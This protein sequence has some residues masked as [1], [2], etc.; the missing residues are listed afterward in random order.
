[1]TPTLHLC[2]TYKNGGRNDRKSEVWNA[3][4]ITFDIETTSYCPNPDAK[5]DERQYYGCMYHWQ[6]CIDGTVYRGRLM[7]DLKDFLY[8][9]SLQKGKKI[10]WVH[11]LAFEYQWLMNIFADS[12]IP[13]QVFARTSRKP[14]KATWGSLEFRCTYMLTNMSLA[15]VGKAFNLPVRKME[16]DLDYHKLR[17]Y[18]TPLTDEELKYC[19]NDVLVVYHLIKYFK[20]IYQRVADIP[21][22]STGRIRRECQKFMRKDSN[23][24]KRVE[25]AYPDAEMF[26]VFRKCFYGG[27]THSN[28]RR[29]D[30]IIPNVDSFDIA[31]SYPTV[32]VSEVFPMKFVRCY[33]HRIIKE[34]NT[35]RL[36]HIK[37]YNVEAKG[38]FTYLSKSKCECCYNAITDNGRILSAD[39]VEIFLTDIDLDI[40]MENYNVFQYDII[41]CWRAY[42]RYLPKTFLEYVF[43]LY[44]KKTALKNVEGME[45]EYMQSKAFL[46]SLYGMC[47][48]N[49]IRDEIEFDQRTGEW[50]VR[51]LDIKEIDE[52]LAKQAKSIKTFLLYQWGLYITAYARRNLWYMIKRIDEDCIYCDTDSI[53]IVN[54]EKYRSLIEQYNKDIGEKIARSV[55]LNR[56]EVNYPPRDPSGTPRPLGIY[57]H[58]KEYP[59][60]KFKTLGAKK[61]CY[62]GKDDQLHITVSGVTKRAAPYL[63]DIE[64]FKVG[65]IFPAG[66]SGRTI[67]RYIN[68]QPPFEFVDYLGIRQTIP[69][70]RYA[71]NLEE[72]TYELGLDAKYS[73]LIHATSHL[74]VFGEQ[75]I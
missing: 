46:N 7:S 37:L 8:E 10:I 11:N 74:A 67:A 24:K 20:A 70:Q 17:G 2:K 43:K 44:E 13:L 51:T 5:E 56:L 22:T 50:K 38:C 49:D 55:Y 26:A 59:V 25:K 57:D 28:F 30:M 52:K 39:W 69:D 60:K 35:N 18:T 9:L 71:I 29:T 16:G 15:E 12:E 27:Y 75:S 47:V 73:D 54:S 63:G 32:M 42:N 66:I 40:V 33:D 36:Y 68:D 23:N 6:F 4:I 48:T 58:E 21:L 19:E 61:Y 62:L 1:M 64:N 41:E 14:I 65:F 53:K 72:T 34:P 3:A 31:S 45:N